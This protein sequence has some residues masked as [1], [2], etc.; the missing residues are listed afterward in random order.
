VGLVK[1]LRT[2][3]G[4]PIKE[5]MKVLEEAKGDLHKAED[6]LKKK[7]LADAEKRLGRSTS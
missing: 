3:T 2:M 5:C 4:A 6:L 7:G 1:K